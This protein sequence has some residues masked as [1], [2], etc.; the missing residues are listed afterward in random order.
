MIRN[1]SS[2]CILPLWQVDE[3][4]FSKKINYK[5]YSVVS[6]E[7]LI[8]KWWIPFSICC[9]SQIC[10]SLRRWLCHLSHFPFFFILTGTLMLGVGAGKGNIN[11][12][13]TSYHLWLHPHR[14]LGERSESLQDLRHISE[15][16]WSHS[17]Q[18]TSYE[19]TSRYC[20]SSQE[21]SARTQTNK[22]APRKVS[23]CH[24]ITITSL[25]W[26]WQYDCGSNKW[27]SHK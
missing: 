25:H 21:G 10:N 16:T 9:A 14:P 19:C 20:K 18:L 2:H 6:Q 22:T 3:T 27:L 23:L 5:S 7:L 12:W 1:S 4:R 26:W 11:I 15:S 13:T 17:Q 8:E 24:G